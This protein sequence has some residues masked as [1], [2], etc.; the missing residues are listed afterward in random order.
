[1]GSFDF[2]GVLASESIDSAQDDKLLVK[3]GV[4]EG[5]WDLF[6]DFDIETF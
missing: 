4:G 2:A 3:L 6:D 5:D 1:M